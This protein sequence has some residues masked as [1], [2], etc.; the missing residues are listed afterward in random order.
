TLPVAA[1]ATLNINTLLPEQAPLL[2]MLAPDTLSVEA[3]QGALLRRPPQG[4]A[5][6][7][8]LAAQPGVANTSL[9]GGQ[10]GVTSTWF[11][12]RIDVALDGA[13]L[14]ETALIDARRLPAR[15]VARQWGEE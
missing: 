3:A 11:A 4:F 9:A 12:L 2:A 6:V 15:L 13:D 10:T 14:H 5:N 7:A 1:P 8:A